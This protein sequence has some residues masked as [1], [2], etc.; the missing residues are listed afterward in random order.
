MNKIL[1]FLPMLIFQGIY[2]QS[3]KVDGICSEADL[4]GV[5][6]D[7]NL[8]S[9]QKY[10]P[11][12]R[13]KKRYSNFEEVKNQ[14]PEEL[15][16]S[17]MSVQ[18][19]QWLAFN[20]ED[21]IN[22]RAEQF[23]RIKTQDSDSN[24]LEIIRKINYSFNDIEH[25]ILRVRVYDDR[26]Q[27]PTI[28]TLMSKKKEGRWVLTRNSSKSAL[29]FFM[30]NLNLTHLD[31]FIENTVTNNNSFNEILRS[32]WKNNV[33]FP[34]AGYKLIGS[35]M[36]NNNDILSDVFE[37]ENTSNEQDSQGYSTDYLSQSNQIES[38]YLIPMSNQIFCTYFSNEISKFDTSSI[39]QIIEYL[40]NKNID[41]SGNLPRITP[42]HEFKFIENG[43]QLTFIKYSIEKEDSTKEIL[44]DVMRYE[45]NTFSKINDLSDRNLLIKSI[46]LRSKSEFIVQISN[47]EDN[48]NHPK[49][50]N[51]KNGI[52]DANGVLNIKKLS[53]LIK[54]S[55][56]NIS[57]YLD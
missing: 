28:V 52:K 3:Q 38:D 19:N 11:V 32:S 25:A 6:I 50:N 23:E 4:F 15:L 12:L 1:F 42:I 24:F 35:T 56:S 21:Q 44:I 10:T 40:K 29:E 46:L 48:P 27:K 54:N 37:E 55:A 30:M 31:S 17:Q 5:S 16:I 41:N 36:L 2:S 34:V 13:L 9:Y 47:G 8:I 51:L 57:E 39:N 7:N 49:I 45:K 53:E 22:W 14:T 18:N 20:F 43:K 33:F 26:R